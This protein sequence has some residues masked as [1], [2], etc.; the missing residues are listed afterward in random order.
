MTN[1]DPT[2]QTPTA[3]AAVAEPTGRRPWHDSRIRRAL[4]AVVVV[5][6]LAFAAVYMWAMWDPT[7]TLEDMPVALVNNDI[8][9]GSGADR[10]AAGDEVKQTLLDSGALKFDAVDTETAV[11]GLASGDYYFV[12]SIPTN[13]SA[14]LSGLGDTTKAPALIS[15]TYNDNNTLLASSIGDSVMSAIRAEVV[16]GTAG[17]S[18]KTVLQG[19]DELSGGLKDAA[20]GS[21]QLHDGTSELSAGAGELAKGLRDELVPGTAEAADGGGQLAAGAGELAAGLT[22][23]R[24]GTDE[25]G[26]GATELADG[27]DSIVGGV[28]A[29][30][31]A[32][33]L[34]ALKKALPNDPS[35]RGI[36]DEL[37]GV[38]DG[39]GQ[40]TSGSREI[41]NQLTNPKAD[42]RSGVEQ[43]V[44]GSAELSSGA[45]ELS[46]GLGEL[47]QGATD[48]ANG[49][50]Q[51]ADGAGQVDDGA[52]ELHQGL[53]D[54]ARQAPDLGDDVQQ[55]SL[56]DLLATPVDT[57][58]TNLAAAQFNGPGGAPLLLIM[59]TAIVP[60]IVFMCCRP[61]RA[62]VTAAR[63][64]GIRAWLRRVAFVCGVSLAAMAA[65]TVGVWSFLS[66]SPDPANL[67]QTLLMVA[68]ATLMHTAVI[69]V[70]FAIGGYVVGSVTALA[71]IMLQMFSFGGVWMIETVPGALKWLHPLMPMTYVRDGFIASFNGSSGFWAALVIVVGITAVCTA[72]H[73]LLVRG[74]TPA[75]D[76][77]PA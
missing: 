36:V 34:K 30:G 64:I 40:L 31:I 76:A 16:K 27:I 73:L 11:D 26:A 18:V 24:S 74:R 8:A 57:K 21:G 51:L 6:P 7:E 39:L 46:A 49:A 28:D 37:T 66:P 20:T 3:E 59:L 55:Q 17:S 29:K 38:V 25:L 12:V 72:A 62:S 19:L 44:A 60:L 53:S 63:T 48:A 13:F 2:T 65:C 1:E 77:L 50:Q 15:I 75:A 56:A 35:I 10:L 5:V 69:G 42:Y 14:T 33:Q 41:A 68:A 61:L 45:N 47:H 23:L 4:L 9:V 71:G 70:M 54:G 43:L 32:D 58:A 67:A 52:G 22:E